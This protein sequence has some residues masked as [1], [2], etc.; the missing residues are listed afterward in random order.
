MHIENTMS[1][2][3]KIFCYNITKQD[4]DHEICRHNKQKTVDSTNMHIP[5]NLDSWII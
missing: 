3:S 4:E 2:D 1:S 5:I